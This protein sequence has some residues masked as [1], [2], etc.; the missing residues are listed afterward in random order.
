MK[1]I[2]YV[3]L[4]ST[5]AMAWIGTPAVMGQSAAV[6]GLQPMQRGV[7]VKMA[8]ASDARP[9][10]E[11]DDQEAW[12]VTVAEDGSLYFGTDSFSSDGLKQQM[13]SHPRKQSQRLYIKADARAK[14]SSVQATL[15]AATAAEFESLVLLTQAASASDRAAPQGLEVLLDAGD[16]SAAGVVSVS[17]SGTVRVNNLDVSESDLSGTL[18]RIKKDATVL[19]KADGDVAYLEV[20]KVVDACRAAAVRVRLMSGFRD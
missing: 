14:F 9:M 16:G 15:Q 3:C 19:V 12:I 13:I 7:S 8:V 20:V 10:L 1:T 4:I 18:R 5:M 2:R 11:A 6:T 17:R